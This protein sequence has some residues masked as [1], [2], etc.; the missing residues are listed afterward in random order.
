MTGEVGGN[1]DGFRAEFG[2]IP[3][4]ESLP[5]GLTEF[6]RCASCGHWRAIGYPSRFSEPPRCWVKDH[7]E[8]EQVTADA[9]NADWTGG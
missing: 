5:D 8:M 7:G 3:E 4:G 9:I 2:M 6:W 1:P